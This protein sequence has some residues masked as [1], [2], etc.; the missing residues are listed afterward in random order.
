MPTSKVERFGD[1]EE[2]AA[3]E[4]ALF[5]SPRMPPK[6]A[7]YRSEVEASLRTWVVDRTRGMTATQ[8]KKLFSQYVG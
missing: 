1:G 2:D 3:D 6:R 8:R 7:R 4:E 5:R